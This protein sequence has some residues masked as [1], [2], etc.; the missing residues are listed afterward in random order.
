MGDFRTTE[1]EGLP[2][3]ASQRR[4][5]WGGFLAKMVLGAAAVALAGFLVPVRRY[6]TAS[7]YV[8][9]REYAEVRSPVTGI[10]KKIL[11]SSGERVEA[12]QILVELNC[13]EEE[14]ALSE[15]NAR[16]SRLRSERERRQA[17]MEIDLS[18]RGV[19]LEEKRRT[20][21]DD[22]RVAELELANAE[23]R[24]ALAK[25]LLEKGLKSQREVEDLSL[26]RELCRVRLDA[27]RRKD[28][29]VYEELL[30]RDREKYSV[31]LRALEEELAALE[32]SARQAQARIEIRQI[33]APIAGQVVRY[34]FVEGEL[35]EPSYVIYEI[36]GGTEQVL[37]LRVEE[38]YA[39]RLA[40]GQPCRARLASYNGA[41]QRIF[42]RGTI[43]HLRDVVQND[44]KSAYRMAYCSFDPGEYPIQ[45]GTTAEARIY[46][47][48]SSFWSFLLNLEP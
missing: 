42:F 4:R 16:V 24:L 33:R 30:E 37:K 20:H 43:Q 8:T 29:K 46:Y 1:G 26:Q 3:T 39:A 44:G 22:L 31:E 7:G 38:R 18:R 32:D 2:E 28:F 15:A 10:V 14:A 12:G 36:F 34:E 21:Q 48:R 40:V 47:A 17:E 19:E 6:A 13:A 23:S 9:T 27:L 5:R 25:D 11:V 41:V 35:L 45:P